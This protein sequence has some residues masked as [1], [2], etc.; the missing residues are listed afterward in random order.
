METSQIENS[1]VTLVLPWESMLQRSRRWLI[2][3]AMSS[4]NLSG[5]ALSLP[6]K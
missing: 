2:I 3:D 4:G 1:V 6:V 5:P